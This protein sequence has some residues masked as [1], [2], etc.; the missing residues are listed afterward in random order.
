MTMGGD[1]RLADFDIYLRQIEASRPDLQWHFKQIQGK[2][3]YIW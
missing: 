3:W 2:M 1:F